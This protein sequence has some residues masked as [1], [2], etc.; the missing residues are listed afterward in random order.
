MLRRI[1]LK[2][3]GVDEMYL[4]KYSEYPLVSIQERVSLQLEAI[5][6]GC[7]GLS[8]EGLLRKCP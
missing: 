3:D 2:I 4:I 5:S 1:R 6:R 7:S 8:P